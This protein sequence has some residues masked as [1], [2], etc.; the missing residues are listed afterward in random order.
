M[1]PRKRLR[2]DEKKK[3]FHLNSLGMDWYKVS[4]H[5][6]EKYLAL[7]LNNNVI[8][9]KERKGKKRGEKKNF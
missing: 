8:L 5:V 1:W 3:P 4:K 7:Y 6:P 2:L 9:V